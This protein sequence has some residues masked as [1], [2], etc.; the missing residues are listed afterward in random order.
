[1]VN[2]ILIVDDEKIFCNAL[3][4]HLIQKGYTVNVCN[5]YLEF[6]EKINLRQFDLILLDLNLGDINGLDLFEIAK[7]L[8]PAIKVIIISAYL[9][10]SSISKAKELGAYDYI[11]KNTRLFQVLDQLFEG[12]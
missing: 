7:E 11:S 10:H 4:Y 2:R 9:D 12:I 8:N 5:S 3:K 1:M 6:Q